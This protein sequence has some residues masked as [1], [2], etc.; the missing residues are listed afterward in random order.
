VI[1]KVVRH[2]FNISVGGCQKM[3]NKFDIERGT[4]TSMGLETLCVKSSTPLLRPLLL[5]YH[6][7]LEPYKIGKKLKKEFSFGH[8][9]VF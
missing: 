2:K 4:N 7:K 9:I 6:S 3:L 5:G 8:E 1:G